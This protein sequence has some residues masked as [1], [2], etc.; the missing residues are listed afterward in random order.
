MSNALGRLLGG[1]GEATPGASVRPGLV[2][3]V[4]KTVTPWTIEVEVGGAAHPDVVSLGWYDPQVG[5][6]VMVLQQGT[7]LLCLG[8]AAPGK[9]SAA[10]APA[11]PPPPPA[12]APPPSRRTVTV[13]AVGS[14]SWDARYSRWRTDGVYQGGGWVQR[15]FWYY[16]G[17]IAAAKG[18]GTI[19][20]A[21]IYIARSSAPHGVAGDQEANV[22]LGVHGHA[23]EPGTG[24]SAHSNIVRVGGLARGKAKTF[25]LSSGHLALLNAGSPG[26][27][28]E[29]GALGY[30]SAD[31]LIAVPR[32]AGDTSGALTLTIQD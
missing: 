7:G 21:S 24:G 12:P 32:S 17:G 2:R 30:Q 10:A 13:K 11:P 9:V 3:A 15:G 8:T 5:D 29:P 14:S 1:E 23:A 27:G 31:Y 26:L 20:A 16:G 22:R 19:V 4:D 25:A 28:L 6:T 18:S